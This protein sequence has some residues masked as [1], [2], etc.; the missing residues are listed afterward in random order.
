[1][2][3]LLSKILAGGQLSESEAYGLLDMP[4]Q[5]LRDGAAD[6]T[7]AMCP[8]KFDSCSIINARSG[9]CSE[10]CKWCAQSAHHSTGCEVYG[11]VDP[12][13]C[14]T[15]AAHHASRGVMRFS[16]VASGRAV[17]GRE[18]TAMASMLRRAADTTGIYTCASMGLIG[19]KEMAELREAGVQRY[20]CNLETAPSHFPTLC[21]TH[22]IADKL[23]TIAAA[24]RAGMEIC[25]GGIIGMGETERQRVEFALTLREIAPDSI[26]VNILAPIKGTPL[27]DTPLISDDEILDAIAILR[28]INP[29]TTLRW[30]GGRARLSDEV[31]Q[32]GMRIGINGGMVGDLLTTVGSKIDDD[33]DAVTRAGY[34]F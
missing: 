3:Q 33:I 34:I 8:R 6:I 17:K 26:P 11:L 14:Q 31:Q 22:T 24:R 10:N 5:Q 20:H 1:M 7:S 4:R 15:M 29:R 25:S 13:V 23:E 2:E 30:A 16:L 19:D 9:R 32:Q 21:S 12:E 27:E 18:L 28:W